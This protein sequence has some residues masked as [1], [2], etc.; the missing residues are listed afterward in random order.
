MSESIFPITG[1]RV[2]P[3]L[4]ISDNDEL[5]SVQAR[6]NAASQGDPKVRIIR[7]VIGSLFKATMVSID[8]ENCKQGQS[9][10]E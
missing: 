3:I 4:K 2:E 8:P 5:T 7:I 10:S 9:K 6:K 1:R